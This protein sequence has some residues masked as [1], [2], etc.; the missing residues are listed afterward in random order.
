MS[1]T[2]DHGQLNY[3]DKCPPNLKNDR[4]EYKPPPMEHFGEVARQFEWLRDETEAFKAVLRGF[5]KIVDNAR[6]L[7]PEAP[8]PKK[9]KPEA[10]RMVFRNKGKKRKAKGRN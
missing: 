8:A 6:A 4:A 3:C 7:D 1:S 5:G 9:R 2:C 10:Q